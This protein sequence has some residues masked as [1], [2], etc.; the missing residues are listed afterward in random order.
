MIDIV[1]LRAH[2]KKLFNSQLEP[3]LLKKGIRTQVH[4]IT[5]LPHLSCVPWVHFSSNVILLTFSHEDLE[6]ILSAVFPLL[7]FS[8]H[9]YKIV[10]FDII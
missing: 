2:I 1:I 5:Y 10:N 6:S 3:N 9:I 4:K 8:F 7:S